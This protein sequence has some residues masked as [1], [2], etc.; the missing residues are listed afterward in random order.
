MSDF[1][2]AATFNGP[3][4]QLYQY[5]DNAP[6]LQRW[7]SLPERR[8]RQIMCNFTPNGHFQVVYADPEGASHKVLGQYLEIETDRSL[9][10]T[11]QWHPDG[12][13]TQVSLLFEAINATTTEVLLRHSGFTDDGEALWHQHA[14][15][16]AF[17]TLAI[18][19]HQATLRVPPLAQPFGCQQQ[20]WA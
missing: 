9:A 2:L 6:G 1:S 18:H 5:F 20:L 13:V 11:W 19:L 8:V 10:F 15:S 3:V 16:F 12:Q 14:W 4:Q 7:L 17:E